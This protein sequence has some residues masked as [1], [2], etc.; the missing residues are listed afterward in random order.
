MPGGIGLVINV[1]VFVWMVQPMAACKALTG[2]A[3]SVRCIDLPVQ[4]SQYLSPA[5]VIYGGI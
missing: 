2:V 1:F 5:Q 3:M 4:A